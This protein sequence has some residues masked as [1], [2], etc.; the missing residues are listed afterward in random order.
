MC[1]AMALFTLY[2]PRL[3]VVRNPAGKWEVVE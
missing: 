3:T 1:A 2:P